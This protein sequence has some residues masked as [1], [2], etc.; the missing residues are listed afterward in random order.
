[1]GPELRGDRAFFFEGKLEVLST[2]LRGDPPRIDENVPARL[3]MFA[4]LLLLLTLELCI[5]GKL[6]LLLQSTDFMRKLGTNHSSSSSSHL[7]LSII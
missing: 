4:W 1:M 2:L 3:S 6:L 7:L 5:P